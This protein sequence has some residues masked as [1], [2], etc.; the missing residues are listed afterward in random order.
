MAAGVRRSSRWL[1]GYRRGLMASDIAVVVLAVLA[2]HLLSASP[3]AA[4]TQWFGAATLLLGWL[5][6]LVLSGLWDTMEFDDGS[7]EYRRI[8]RAG[9]IIFTLTGV[10]G[11]LTGLESA[12]S[13]LL[14][15]LP[16]GTAVLMLC[17]W[18][19]RRRMLHL[20]RAGNRLQP[21]LVVGG[22]VAVGALCSTVRAHRDAGYQVAGVFLLQDRLH[23]VRQNDE[24]DGYPVVGRAT[25]IEAVATDVAA[26]AVACGASFI[27]SADE[28]PDLTEELLIS[29]AD[30]GI[31]LLAMRGSVDLPGI[32]TRADDVVSLEC[33][34]TDVPVA[35]GPLPV[36]SLAVGPL[37]VQ[38]LA[39]DSR[40]DGS[41]G[42]AA[43][44]LLVALLGLVL[45]SPLLLT[46]GLAVLIADG[47]PIIHRT[48]YVGLGGVAFPGWSFRCTPHGVRARP[49]LRTAAD[50][51]SG[52]VLA[53]TPVGRLLRRTGLEV[54][55]QL[56]NVLVRQMSLVGPVPRQ[57]GEVV[58]GPPLVR[59]GITGRWRISP[60]GPESAAAGPVHSANRSDIDDGVNWSVGA[61]IAII[62]STLRLALAGRLAA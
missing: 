29:L 18:G 44:D 32:S 45:L 54:A 8:L 35:V 26:A 24:V 5:T 60:G 6:A 57:A 59:P 51:D 19:W 30:T 9:M 20:R 50:K 40:L 31:R 38:S 4:W 12:R 33:T 13:Y 3:I 48:S 22:R 34:P 17:H 47:G 37:Q 55:P 28:Y 58:T 62:A 56:L 25:E 7:A 2:A 53:V 11:F 39:V 36:Q 41:T 16:A 52:Y 46:A 1:S 42:K 21:L 49:I 43:F 15:A 61:D 23:V 14:I 10:A 27:A